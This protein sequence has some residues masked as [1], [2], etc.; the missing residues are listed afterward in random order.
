MLSVAL[1]GVA[2]TSIGGITRLVG[3][4]GAAVLGV[5]TSV[6][7]GATLLLGIALSGVANTLIGGVAGFI[8][9]TTPTVDRPG[10]TAVVRG[11][12]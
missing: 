11:S 8:A 12:L 3:A 2:N 4:T 5:A 6:G 9:A 7:H 1:H 10:L